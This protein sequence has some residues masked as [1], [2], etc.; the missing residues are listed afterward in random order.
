MWDG[1]EIGLWTLGM[2]DAASTQKDVE[3]QIEKNPQIMEI[4][5]RQYIVGHG[6]PTYEQ[7]FPH[8]PMCVPFNWKAINNYWSNTKHGRHLNGINSYYISYTKLWKLNVC[9]PHST[10]HFSSG[11]LWSD[12]VFSHFT[13]PN[14][15]SVCVC[16][17]LSCKGRK[18]SE[19]WP[20]L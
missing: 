6:C 16:L 7:H 4:F 5:D 2:W 15:L 8:K 18:V 20:T 11:I 17:L 3:H 14:Q 13:V 1:R 19:I 12:A 10:Q 9:I